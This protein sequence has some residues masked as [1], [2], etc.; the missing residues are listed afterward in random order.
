M[1]SVSISSTDIASCRRDGRSDGSA[2]SV[3]TPATSLMQTASLS[4]TVHHVD[5]C[6]ALD[7][8]SACQVEVP[9]VHSV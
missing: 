6:R 7:G 2:R 4:A 8:L 9:K 5:Q 1:A 3:G